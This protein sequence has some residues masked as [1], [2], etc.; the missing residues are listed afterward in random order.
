MQAPILENLAAYVYCTSTLHSFGISIRC[1]Y[2][3]W[4]R[5]P[6]YIDLQLTSAVYPFPKEPP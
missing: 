1:R 2:L 4:H 6:L 3:I 5:D